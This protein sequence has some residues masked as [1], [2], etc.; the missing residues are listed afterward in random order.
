MSKDTC[1]V[2]GCAKSRHYSNGFCPMHYQR[3][4]KTGTPG[5]AESKQRATCSFLGCDNRHQSNGL[6]ASHDSQMRRTG[7]LKP[8]R[9]YYA[10]DG[11][12]RVE[13]C[14]RGRFASGYCAM[15][16]SRLQRRGDVGR[17][18]PLY[19]DHM[20]RDAEGRKCC[21]LCGSWKPEADYGWSKATRDGRRPA[22]RSCDRA[23]QTA[24]RHNISPDEMTALLAQQGGTC[25][26]CGTESAGTKS[27]AWHVDHDH[28]CCPGRTTCGECI[29]GL[30]CN[31]CN[32]MLGMAL[33][34][35]ET[36]AA[37]ITYLSR[38]GLSRAV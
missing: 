24:Y 15:H 23:R 12:C 4:R 25:A 8:L 32:V 33:D 29:R 21:V 35:P 20:E 22:C 31:R 5:P 19:P 38:A 16:Y 18:G 2:P 11:M 9:A 14:V 13:G 1:K 3:W 10:R 6:C 7:E 26:V 37:A 30:L 27:G 34:N 36:L 17:P 28:T